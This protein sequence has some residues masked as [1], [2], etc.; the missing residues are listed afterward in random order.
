ML[1]STRR[2]EPYRQ[3]ASAPHIR[4]DEKAAAMMQQ[5]LPV[6]LAMMILAACS[7][8]APT[9]TS[10]PTQ[11]PTPTTAPTPTA[12]AATTPSPSPQPTEAAPT[13]SPTSAGIAV[14]FGG[15]GA[16]NG[17]QLFFNPTA[18]TVPAGDITF[19][20]NNTTAAAHN[21]IIGPDSPTCTAT[22]CTFGPVTAAGPS[23]PAGSAPKSFTVE[24]LA[25]GTYSYWCSIE[26]HAA[27]GMVGTLTVTP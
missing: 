5:F 3:N 21:M 27:L 4:P 16:A 6:G 9:A 19:V 24:G 18:I 23:V 22:A 2:L 11:S 20:L 26:D 17:I 1:S 15:I 8:A 14:Y 13:P 10:S 25:A 12:T 7:A